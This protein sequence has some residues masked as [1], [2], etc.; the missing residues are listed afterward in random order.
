MI[1]D[2]AEANIDLRALE[3][4]LAVA[5][6]DIAALPVDAPLRRLAMAEL[7]AA[8]E[9]IARFAY[10]NRQAAREAAAM[11]ARIVASHRS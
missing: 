4:V 2:L 10:G 3:K 8:C 7:Q 11:L 9:R 1:D 5:F 6:D